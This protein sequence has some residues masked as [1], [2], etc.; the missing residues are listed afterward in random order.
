MLRKTVWFSAFVFAVT[1]GIAV[2]GAKESA[3]VEVPY[4][5]SWAGKVLPA[6]EYTFEWQGQGAVL[7]VTV[8]RGRQVVAQG[9][10]RLEDVQKKAAANAVGTR[11]DTSGARL[12]TRVDFRGKAT[13]LTLS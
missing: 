2:A 12:L 3:K 6:G 8:L 7:D 10:G 11:R 9:H 13:V 1:A 5:V 4:E